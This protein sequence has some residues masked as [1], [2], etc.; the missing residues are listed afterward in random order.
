PAAPSKASSLRQARDEVREFLAFALAGERFA[1]PLG[2]VREIM[3]LAPITEVPRAKP[4]VLGIL[5]VRGRITTVFDLR[6]RLRMPAAEPTRASRIRRV[7]GADEVV[8][9]L[10]ASVDQVFR[11]QED[12][13]ELAA[14]V[15]G[16][17]SDYVL[18]V[19]RPGGSTREDA[20][21]LILLDP[22]PL[23]RR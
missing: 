13:I 22:E 19:G 8:G 3:K 23:L 21:I 18:G 5:S 16:G 7:A 11:L 14:A 20:D 12:E 9:L 17:L 1:L 4:H 2:A 15:A 10:V 6:K